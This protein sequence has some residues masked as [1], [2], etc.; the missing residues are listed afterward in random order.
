MN[1]FS[2]KQK[3]L[4]EDAREIKLDL[5]TDVDVGAID[6]WAPPE[7]E[8][9]IRDLIQTRALRIGELLVAHGLFE[10]GRLLPEQTLPSGEVRA[11]EE[12]VLE[13]T[14]HTAEC[15]DDIDTIVVKL[16][17]FAVVA[18]G[19][20]PEGVTAQSYLALCYWK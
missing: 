14:F 18:L 13:D 15:G 17:Q 9:T 20:P 2:P 16:P 1:Q 5:E 6:C 19:R 7:R 3:G 10:T 8:A 4:H 12:R 11:L